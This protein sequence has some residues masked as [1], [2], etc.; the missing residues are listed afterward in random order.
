VWAKVQGW[1]AVDLQ[2]ISQNHRDAG[3]THVSL[4]TLAPRNFNT[5]FWHIKNKSTDIVPLIGLILSAT[6]SSAHISSA[7]GYHVHRR[8]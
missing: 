5:H 3:L 1:N 7:F 4:Y 8:S 2:A 6:D